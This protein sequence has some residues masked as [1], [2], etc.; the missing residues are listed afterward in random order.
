MQSLKDISKLFNNTHV[1]DPNILE[2]LNSSKISLMSTPN[3]YENIHSRNAKLYFVTFPK[4][5]RRLGTEEQDCQSLLKKWRMLI[6]A[7][8]LDTKALNEETRRSAFKLHGR[9]NAGQ[10][11]GCQWWKASM[12]DRKVWRVIVVR[13]IPPKVSANIVKNFLPKVKYKL[14]LKYRAFWV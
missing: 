13:R 2:Q 5:H 8:S 6:K 4:W 12:Q 11:F 9:T 10:W 7:S 3:T 14:V 1:L